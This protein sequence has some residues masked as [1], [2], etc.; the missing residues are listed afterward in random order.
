MNATLAFGLIAFSGQISEV[1]NY[2]PEPPKTE[3]KT[4]HRGNAKR[5][6][7]FKSNYQ[8][9]GF[10]ILVLRNS[11]QENFSA[12]LIRYENHIEVK[13]K[14]Y[15]KITSLQNQKDFL[16]PHLFHNYAASETDIHKG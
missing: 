7:Y 9:P 16:K 6:A 8:A 5:T 2:N 3:V 14:G 10:N 11:Q 4:I 1:K 12:F 13:L 15:T